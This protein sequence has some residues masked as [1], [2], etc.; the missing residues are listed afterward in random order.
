MAGQAE[1]RT[2]QKRGV[3]ILGVSLAAESWHRMP[4]TPQLRQPD[5]VGRPFRLDRNLG[6]GR[7]RA[8]SRG[9]DSGDDSSGESE[10]GPQ[11]SGRLE[12]PEQTKRWLADRRRVLGGLTGRPG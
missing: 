3:R 5:V 12:T 1:R 11:G 2:G 6:C 4:T 10:P 7:P 8:S 9:G